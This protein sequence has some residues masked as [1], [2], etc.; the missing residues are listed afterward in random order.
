[1]ILDFKAWLLLKI[2]HTQILFKTNK[3][4]IDTLH[5]GIIAFI[6]EILLHFTIVHS[7][8]ASAYNWIIMCCKL[9]VKCE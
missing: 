2:T 4:R 6:G 8:N 1:M 7:Q 3:K 5:F 9:F